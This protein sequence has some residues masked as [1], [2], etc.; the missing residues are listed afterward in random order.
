[1]NHAYKPQGYSSVSVYVVAQG[2]Q[3]VIDFLT[4]A[5]DA[6]QT[7]RFDMPDG[8][9]MHAEVQIDDTVVVIADG[10]GEAPALHVGSMCMCPTWMLPTD[11][12][13]PRVASRFRNPTKSRVTPTVAGV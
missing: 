9:I 10:G 8:S 13:S 5:F 6:R 7:R 11:V 1:M 4:A 12:P 3:R 2:A